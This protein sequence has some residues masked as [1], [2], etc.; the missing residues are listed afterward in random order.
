MGCDK[1]IR[2]RKNGFLKRIGAGGYFLIFS[3]G[4][5][6]ANRAAA[7]ISILQLL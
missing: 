2:T 6:S 3:A 5:G 4:N 1:L 7:F